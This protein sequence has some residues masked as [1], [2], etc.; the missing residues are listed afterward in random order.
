MGIGG[1]GRQCKEKGRQG[2]SESVEGDGWQRSA[3]DSRFLK[4][5]QRER[6][7]WISLGYQ[8]L[9]GKA[10]EGRTVCICGRKPVVK[11]YP[12]SIV[13]FPVFTLLVLDA[14]WPLA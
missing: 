4:E 2:Q 8:G 12:I 6:Y 13:E 1:R 11:K 7:G 10:S 14:F 9:G 5:K 3:V